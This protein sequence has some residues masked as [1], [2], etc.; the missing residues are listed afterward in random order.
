[1]Q[2]TD[3]SADWTRFEVLGPR[4]ADCVEA[5][6]QGN[7]F[8]AL[9]ALQHVSGRV[10]S[11]QIVLAKDDVG[12]ILR[13]LIWVRAAATGICTAAISEAARRMEMPEID[14]AL[15]DTIRI[16]AGRPA[17]VTDIDEQVIP[18]ETLQVE[19]GISYVKG[20]YLGQ[21]VLERMRSRGSMA[22]KL[23]GLQIEGDRLPEHNAPIFAA[24]K[25]AGRVTSAC[26]SPALGGV[27]AMGYLKSLLVS[28]NQELQVASS[29][30]STTA[31]RIVSLPLPVWS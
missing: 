11:A 1:V 5:L 13:A 28:A 31:A 22:R 10:G 4:T 25:E 16:E 14:A 6:G 2:L 18:P 3:I 29:E 17:S 30:A 24:G 19:R 12:P 26:Q 27:L 9:P 21:E 8:A 7:N 15:F 20:C 23:V